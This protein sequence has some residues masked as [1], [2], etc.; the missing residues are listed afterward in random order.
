MY[1]INLY[2]L[3][4][5]QRWVFN[6]LITCIPLIFKFHTFGSFNFHSIHAGLRV[7]RADSYVYSRIQIVDRLYVVKINVYE[8]YLSHL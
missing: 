7:N 8:G 3:A 1:N 4:C 2:P 6:M 5:K